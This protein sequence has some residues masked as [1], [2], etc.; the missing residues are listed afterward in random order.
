MPGR[1]GQ[2]GDMRPSVIAFDVNETSVRHVAA[3]RPVRRGGSLRDGR[4]AVVRLR[5]ARRLRADRGGGEPAFRRRRHDLLVSLLS[6]A[7]LNRSVDE[8]AGHVMDG[9]AALEVHADVASG[10]GPA[11][12]GRLPA[13]HVEQRRRRR[14]RAAAQRS[15]QLRDR[16]ERLLSVEDAE[17]W[18]PAPAPYRHAASVCGVEPAADGA[19][20]GPP[21]GRRRRGRAG[22]QSVWV[23]RSEAAFP[24]TSR[25]RP[26]P[27]PSID[28]IADLWE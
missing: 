26:T 2:G 24:S 3:G 5:A 9:F 7:Q 25:G 8:A 1:V 14:C 15:A 13:R 19:G 6:Q 11:A 21:V 4:A 17:A 10:S 22:L 18:K 12:R 28:E 16:F 20:R 23:N 27:W